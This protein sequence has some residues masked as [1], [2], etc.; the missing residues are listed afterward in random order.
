M[1]DFQFRNVTG[2]YLNCFE[3][4]GLLL[5]AGEGT[6]GQL[7]RF[8]GRQ[9]AEELLRSLKLIWISHVHA[10][11]HIGLCM[12]LSQRKK[13]MAAGADGNKGGGLKAT[14]PEPVEL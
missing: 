2:I 4:G 8:Y 13:L 14:R 5:D 12:L 7:C 3:R 1:R 10:D 6:F 11:H 9:R